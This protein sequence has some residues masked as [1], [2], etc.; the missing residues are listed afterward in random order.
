MSVEK[1]SEEIEQRKAKE[2]ADEEARH[3]KIMESFKPF[4]EEQERKKRAAQAKLDAEEAERKAKAEK[5]LE[6]QARDLFFVGNP[7]A[8]EN[9]YKAV[10]QDVRKQI[11]FANA[12]KQA[13]E[14]EEARRRQ[15]EWTRRNL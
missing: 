3:A 2:K 6:Q 15:W 12:K 10:R 1:I 5:E 13:D 14:L 9:D 7:E 8:S 11:L 4:L